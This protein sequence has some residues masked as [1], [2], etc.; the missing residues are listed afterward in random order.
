MKQIT[1][2]THLDAIDGLG[3]EKVEMLYD[4]YGS[5]KISPA[6]LKSIMQT[7]KIRRML[8]ETKNVA[9]IAR[10]VKVSKMKVYREMKKK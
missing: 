8:A 10:K 9:L 5:E 7:E 3:E 4:L 1:K 2:S 6:T